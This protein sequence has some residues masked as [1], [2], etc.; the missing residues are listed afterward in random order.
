MVQTLPTILWTL[1]FIRVKCKILKLISKTFYF[2]YALGESAMTHLRKASVLIS[3][4][5][6]VGL[7]IAKNVI[8]GMKFFILFI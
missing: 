4:I 3:G 5:G 1:I 8:L 2:S 6:S 7:E